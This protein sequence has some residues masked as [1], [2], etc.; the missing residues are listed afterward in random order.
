MYLI[1]ENHDRRCTMVPLIEGARIVPEL[2]GAIEFKWLSFP[3]QVARIRVQLEVGDGLLL[4]SMTL[5]RIKCIQ[6]IIFLILTLLK[7][8]IILIHLIL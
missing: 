1:K 7:D 3:L 2:F 8:L 4:R 5:R 6:I